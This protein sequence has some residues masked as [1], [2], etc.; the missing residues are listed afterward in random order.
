MIEVVTI[1]RTYIIESKL[2]EQCAARPEAA[3]K[4]LGAPGLFLE[5]F[6]KV[7]GKL[8]SDIAQR[9]VGLAG[10]QPRQIGRHGAHRRRDGH[11]IVVEDD[12]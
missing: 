5:E 4:F 9:A 6:R 12:D 1:D 3:R 10:D 8:F 2:L 11:I 7:M